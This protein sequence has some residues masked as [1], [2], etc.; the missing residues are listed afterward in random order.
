[1]FSWE[2]VTYVWFH[3]KGE[4]V[5]TSDFSM[6]GACQ[7]EYIVISPNIEKII[8]KMRPSHEYGKYPRRQHHKQQ[9]NTGG[10]KKNN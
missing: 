9:N 6:L 8:Q 10:K 5:L 1:M 4:W 2:I 7:I 3:C